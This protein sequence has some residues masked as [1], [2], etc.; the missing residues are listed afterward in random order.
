M[1]KQ[2]LN[3]VEYKGKDDRYKEHFIIN[4]GINIAL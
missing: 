4:E 2:Y 1:T 3:G